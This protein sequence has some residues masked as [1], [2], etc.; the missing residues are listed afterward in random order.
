M[1]KKIFSHRKDNINY[2]IV[3]QIVVLKFKRVQKNNIS[4]II[5][6]TLWMIKLLRLCN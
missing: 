3:D 4:R 2:K 5:A 1:C 6:S